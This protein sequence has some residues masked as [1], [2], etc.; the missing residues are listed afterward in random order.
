MIEFQYFKKLSCRAHFLLKKGIFPTQNINFKIDLNYIINNIINNLAQLS[1]SNNIN[2][3]LNL[4]E[5]YVFSLCIRIYSVNLVKIKFVSSYDTF[6]LLKFS[7]LKRIFS[8]QTTHLKLI[9]DQIL[10]QQFNLLISPMID[11]LLNRNQF[12]FRKGKKVTHFIDQLHSFLTKTSVKTLNLVKIDLQNNLNS[13]SYNIILKTFPWPAKFIKFLVYILK[14]IIYI[15]K[16]KQL[17]A[18]NWIIQ[19][20]LTLEQ[21]MFNFIL[22]QCLNELL[23]QFN[24]DFYKKNYGVCLNYAT[25]II[26]ISNQKIN[27]RFFLKEFTHLTSQKGVFINK[28]KIKFYTFLKPIK[29]N[30]LGWSIFYKPITSTILDNKN[31]WLFYPSNQNYKNIKLEIKKEIQQ[32]LTKPIW[33]I[34]EKVNFLI[35]K[36]FNYYN[37]SYN[38]IR[39]NQLSHFCFKNWKKILIK[40]FKFRGI[41][42]PYWILKKFFG[43]KNKFSKLEIGRHQ[44]RIQVPSLNKVKFIWQILPPKGKKKSF[45]LQKCKIPSII[46]DYSYYQVKTDYLIF[47]SKMRNL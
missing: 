21:V 30:I 26:F 41:R 16:K 4:I 29:F 13:Q 23:P 32:I 31:F 44:I 10:K 33:H 34:L 40:K 46:K 39:F 8:T 2:R 42:R 38:F 25:K 9:L 35:K 12:G 43:V 22:T 19:K 47:S 18:S 1:I 27:Q 7:Q 45:F 5:K 36:F 3:A 14:S 11:P 15:K 20:K 24:K 37:Y 6:C 28:Q 17:L